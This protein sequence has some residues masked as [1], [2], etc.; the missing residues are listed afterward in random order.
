MRWKSVSRGGVSDCEGGGQ[1]SHSEQFMSEQFWLIPYVAESP[2]NI[3]S[4][5]LNALR[6]FLFIQYKK[7]HKDQQDL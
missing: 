5:W 3:T 6:S 2:T 4:Q 1:T 7:L